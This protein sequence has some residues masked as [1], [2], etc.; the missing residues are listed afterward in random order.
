[1]VLPEQDKMRSR[2]HMGVPVLGVQD[3]GFALGYRFTNVMGL[4][5]YRMNNLQPWE[6]SSIVGLPIASAQISGTAVPGQMITAVVAGAAVA[7]TVQSSDLANGAP[8]MSVVQNLANAINAQ[9]LGFSASAQP[10]VSYPVSAVGATSPYWQLAIVSTLG[11]VFSLS[12]TLSTGS[13][14]YAA[15]TSQ[16][17]APRPFYTFT[18]DNFT[19]TGYLAICDYLESKV[20][21]ASD[22]SSK[23]HVADVVTFRRD[24]LTARDD[25][26]HWWR[27]KLADVFGIPLYP[28]Q[29]VSGFGG[30]NTGLTV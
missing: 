16:G 30:S 3:S 24:E 22:L 25:N 17:V 29:P 23:Y 13:T 21:S 15:V 26:Y 20:G 5:E 10:A 28:M 12:L 2:I 1:M 18:D 19:A 27:Q 14:L 6:I 8:I 9:N 4:F 7:Y 11:V